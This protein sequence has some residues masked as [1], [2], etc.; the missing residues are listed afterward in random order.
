MKQVLITGG[1]GFIGSHL[2]DE[3]LANGYRVRVLDTLEAQVHGEGRRRPD[4]LDAS[5]EIVVGDVCDRET[6]QKALH[7][8]DAVYHFASAVGV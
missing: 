6:V 8:V 7:G 1:A 3:L 5:V 4:Y 2:A